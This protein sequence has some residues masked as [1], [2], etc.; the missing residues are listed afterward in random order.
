[1]GFSN[2]L[3]GGA[4]SQQHSNWPCLDLPC[5]LAVRKDES[6]GSHALLN[7]SSVSA[8][9]ELANLARALPMLNK[10][11]K[12]LK[13]SLGKFSLRTEAEL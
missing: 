5:I 7:E 2:V 12:A 1:M 8:L 11:A 4:V 3:L 9:I 10:V 6:D 13:Q